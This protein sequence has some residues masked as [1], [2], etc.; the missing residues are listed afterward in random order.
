VVP[1]EGAEHD[2]LGLALLAFANLDV[3]VIAAHAAAGEMHVADVGK[4]S[5]QVRQQRRLARDRSQQQV[6]QT[7]ADDGV[8][9]RV[10][11]VRDRIDLHHMPFGALAVILRKFAE[12]SFG[13]AHGSNRP[14]ITPSPSAGTRKSLVRHL[15]TDSGRR[16]S[17]P[18]ISSSSTSIGAMAWD[19]SS[20]SGSI[21]TTMAASSG[22]PPCSAISKNMWAWRGRS[23]T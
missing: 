10:H 15:P 19:A 6:L 1:G 17:A 12:R 14:P 18:A 3:E 5:L 2:V 7:A 11:A 13:L 22:R 21:P 8:E 16:C 20:V 4:G 23:S 9:D